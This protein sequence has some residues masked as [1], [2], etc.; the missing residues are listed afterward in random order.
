[1]K[2]NKHLWLE[3]RVVQHRASKYDYSFCNFCPRG[4]LFQP[5]TILAGNRHK[6]SIV[7]EV[8]RHYNN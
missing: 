6:R 8:A 4:N 2:V 1:M 5:N 7:D 3:S